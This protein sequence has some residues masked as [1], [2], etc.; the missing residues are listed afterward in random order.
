MGRQLTAQNSLAATSVY[1]NV[2]GAVFGFDHCV[3][4][5][6]QLEAK[7][8]EQNTSF[9]KRYGTAHMTPALSPLTPTGQR[10]L[11]QAVSSAILGLWASTC[12]R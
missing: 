10:V 3:F 5:A 7:E 2:L 11:L 12:Y 8:E 1:R 4:K 6:L 9:G